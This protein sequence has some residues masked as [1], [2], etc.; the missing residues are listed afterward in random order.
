MWWRLNFLHIVPWVLSMVLKFTLESLLHWETEGNILK[1]FCPLW[2]WAQLVEIWGES[3][4][5]VEPQI[6]LICF[7]QLDN[8]LLTAVLYLHESVQILDECAFTVKLKRIWPLSDFLGVLP[9]HVV[10][11]EDEERPVDGEAVLPDRN[12]VVQGHGAGTLRFGLLESWRYTTCRHGSAIAVPDA[13]WPSIPWTQQA[14]DVVSETGHSVKSKPHGRWDE[15]GEKMRLY[16]PRKQGAVPRSAWQRRGGE[17]LISFRPSS[18]FFC[19]N[20]ATGAFKVRKEK[21]QNRSS[22]QPG[23]N[24]ESISPNKSLCAKTHKS[25]KVIQLV[26]I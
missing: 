11:A 13:L 10:L 18:G 2:N 15:K 24:P 4:E 25:Q 16:S 14:R 26:F 9:D 5:T 8:S 17:I 7:N 21:S 19:N 3:I 6:N 1:H 12:R 23:Q 20:T 22:K